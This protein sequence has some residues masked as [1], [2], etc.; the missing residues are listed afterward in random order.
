MLP[1]IRKMEVELL[2]LR[3]EVEKLRRE[4]AGLK[5]TIEQHEETIRKHETK[6]DELNGKILLQDPL[7]KIGVAI[8]RRWVE[9]AKE[10]IGFGESSKPIIMEGNEAAHHAA[11]LADAAMWRLGYTQDW[12]PAFSSNSTHALSKQNFER[13]FLE[14]YEKNVEKYAVGTPY[15]DPSKPVST[16][17]EMFNIKATFKLYT[18]NRASTATMAEIE[19][20]LRYYEL[21]K[22]Y[23]LE[24]WVKKS[25]V[26]SA[27]VLK[28]IMREMKEVLAG[29][30]QSRRN[31]G[32]AKNG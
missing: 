4:N 2:Q 23:D 5:E 32:R 17:V 28:G 22:E 10:L 26:E 12:E 31:T 18:V 6:I 15:A 21:L 20:R 9:Q 27:P 16:A 13:V 14:V 25:D 8:R 11:W 29:I 3:L 24:R 19:Y 7:V 30:S 1:R